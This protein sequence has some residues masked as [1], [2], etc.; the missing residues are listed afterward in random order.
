M[1]VTQV[2]GLQYWEM[3]SKE[4]HFLIALL[5]SSNRFFKYSFLCIIY[6]MRQPQS[7]LLSPLQRQ[8]TLIMQK[9]QE[10]VVSLSLKG[11]YKLC[12]PT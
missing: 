7:L 3:T 10:N 6:I 1:N 2:I 12:I 11:N 5:F 8:T 4:S 9:K